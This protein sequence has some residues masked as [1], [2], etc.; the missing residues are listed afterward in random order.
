ME[1]NNNLV[2]IITKEISFLVAEYLEKY[3]KNYPFSNELIKYAK[4]VIDNEEK[5]N[6]IWTTI[7]YEFSKA[8]VIQDYDLT[9]HFV[10]IIEFFLIE[11][12]YEPFNKSIMNKLF[13]SIEIISKKSFMKALN[14]LH[15]INNL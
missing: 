10:N 15:I 11:F 8:I 4:K 9:L 13:K 1:D 5:L 3:N 2:K 12:K 7:D 6:I 14:V